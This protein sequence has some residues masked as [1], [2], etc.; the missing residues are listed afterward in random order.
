MRPRVHSQGWSEVCV[1]VCVSSKTTSHLEDLQ[2]YVSHGQIDLRSLAIGCWVEAD[3][4]HLQ[5]TG[6]L[7][8]LKV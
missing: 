4:V 6:D 8:N 5:F 2:A 1:C 7:Q 3:A